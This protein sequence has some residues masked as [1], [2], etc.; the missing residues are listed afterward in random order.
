MRI[1][2]ENTFLDVALFNAAHQL[3]SPLLQATFL[4]FTLLFVCSFQPPFDI[5]A[6][7]FIGVIFYLAMWLFQ[8]L[9]ACLYLYSRK[10]HTVLT[11]HVIELQDKALMEET[12]FNTS[13]FYW[14][15]GIHKIV[16]RAN[17]VA[18]YISPFMAHIIPPRAFSSRE[19]RAEFIKTVQAKINASA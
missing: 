18:V 15:G 8:L 19:Q 10:N 9:F 3:R 4:L 1:E 7:V 17:R 11:Q 13:Y 16:L 2:Y 5:G 14:S 12:R 6:S